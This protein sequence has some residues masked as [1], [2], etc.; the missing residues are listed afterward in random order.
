MQAVLP[1]IAER[2]GTP[3]VALHAAKHLSTCVACAERL[4]HLR[5]LNGLLDRLPDEEV[6]TSF[7]RRVLRALPRK[8]GA[9]G[10][11]IVFAALVGRGPAHA[12]ANIGI[13]LAELARAPFEAAA[14]ALAAFLF[15]ALEL[16]S[17]ARTALQ[18]A[19]LDL[20]GHMVSAA[21]I[22]PTVGA[23]PVLLLAGALVLGSALAF[24]RSAFAI[25][26]ER[27]TLNL[28]D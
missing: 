21:G 28:S 20:H 27:R 11:L 9:G 17:A 26:R 25:S 24:G 7:V 10:G 1:A 12:V 6:P 15:A 3:R 22:A 8:A 13:Q 5:E 14:S 2:E 4:L 16:A 19:P 18:E 23:L